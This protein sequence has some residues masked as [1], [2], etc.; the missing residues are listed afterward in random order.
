MSI[1]A[2]PYMSEEAGSF[3]A[4]VAAL[5]EAESGEHNCRVASERR[6]GLGIL[7]LHMPLKLFA[8][9][10]GP[11]GLVLLSS[12]SSF[13]AELAPRCRAQGH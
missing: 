3:S 2:W 1:V 5:W 9:N 8:S 10:S 13:V 12:L 7:P 6:E 11:G 4:R